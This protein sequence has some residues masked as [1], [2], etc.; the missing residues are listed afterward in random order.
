MF[1]CGLC[2]EAA[3]TRARLLVAADPVRPGETVLAGVHLRMDK[4]WHTYWRNS[5]ASGAPTTIEWELPKGVTAGAIQWPVPE[6]LP[7]DDL[8]TYIYQDEVVLLV[9]LK[10]AG[11]LPPGPLELKA[12]VEWLECEVLCLRGGAQVQTKLN[13][14]SATRPSPNQ[15]LLGGW[16][17][18]LPQPGEQIH[19]QAWWE[20]TATN[21]VRALIL[22]WNPESAAS[23]ADFFPD[24]SEEF[25]VQAPTERI[26]ADGRR[27][28][29]RKLVKKLSGDWPK[30]ISGVAVQQSGGARSGFDLNLVVHK[31]PG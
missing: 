25:E 30:R 17:K 13:V 3:H 29:L 15:A 5:G 9:P 21:D 26:G 8:T 6:K 12:K 7:D 2:A 18:N 1:C 19:P 11:D 31:P 14:G 20:K 16:Q 4:G 22:E 24:S 27:I 28:R 10:L 23:E